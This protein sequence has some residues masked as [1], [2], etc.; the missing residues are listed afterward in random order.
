MK[1]MYLKW[2][3]YYANTPNMFSGE[4]DNVLY[5]INIIYNVY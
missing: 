4:T 2:R 1:G 5:L 3:L